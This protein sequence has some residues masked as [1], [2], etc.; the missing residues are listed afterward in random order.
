[1]VRILL[2]VLCSSLLL[3]QSQSQSLP[4]TFV[5]GGR[6]WLGQQ[7]VHEPACMTDAAVLWLW[8]VHLEPTTMA[9]LSDTACSQRRNG[10]R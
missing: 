2:L 6:S 3:H 7:A 4:S 10:P 9:L 5:E 8:L 1:M